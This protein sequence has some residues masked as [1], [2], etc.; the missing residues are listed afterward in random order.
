[1]V[2]NYWQTALGALA[3]ECII[4][5]GQAVWRKVQNIGLA[6]AYVNED[7]VRFFVW[8]FLAMAHLPL[9]DHE[10]GLQVLRDDLQGFEDDS[11]QSPRA[12][13]L[14]EQAQALHNYFISTWM[15]GSYDPR[16]W[17]FFDQDDLTTS[18]A[19]ESTNWRFT[20]KT[21]SAHPNVYTSCA[22]IKH[23][24]KET[25][26]Q[27]DLVNLRRVQKRRN[28][29]FEQK[30]AQRSRL[31]EAWSAGTIDVRRYKNCF[32]GIIFQLLLISSYMTAIGALN[33]KVDAKTR[34]RF[35]AQV[36]PANP[37]NH[38]RRTISLV[39]DD[40]DQ[41]VRGLLAATR[42]RQAGQLGPDGG[43]GLDQARGGPRG[44][45]GRR[46]VQARRPNYQELPNGRLVCPA[47]QK[48]YLPSTIRR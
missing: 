38:R 30:Q 20:V 43:G 27:I 42:P 33:L 45:R 2:R 41:N 26:H 3:Y 8:H 6:V 16:T 35:R 25:E 40:V 15:E 9:A 37:E 10:E 19:A 34:E 11:V 13:R 17:N 14:F 29:K 12:M 1:M 21:G 22:A 5:L 7:K 23:D 39:L 47:C 46:Q 44:R 28:Y 31:K 32:W 36:G 24:I 4:Y 48:N 18:N